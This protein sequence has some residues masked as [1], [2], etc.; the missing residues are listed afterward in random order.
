MGFL[1][2]LAAVVCV[3]VVAAVAIG[4]VAAVGSLFLDVAAVGL[5]VWGTYKL[6]SHVRERRALSGGKEPPRVEGRTHRVT[7]LDP[8]DASPPEPEVGTWEAWDVE[9]EPVRETKARETRARETETYGRRHESGRERG[10]TQAT[11][12]TRESQ[13]IPKTYVYLD[14]DGDTSAKDIERV[15]R[16]YR[17]VHV[18][19]SYADYVLDTLDA[20]EFRRRSLLPEIDAKFSQGT[21]SWE[22]FHVTACSALDAVLR[23]CALL[24]NRIQTFDVTEYGRYEQF[25]ADGAFSTNPNPGQATL[26]RWKLVCDTLKEMDELKDATEGLLHELGKLSAELSALDRSKNQENTKDIA[27]EVSRLV[28][29]TR[30]YR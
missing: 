14:V 3:I 24:G 15:M 5:L 2:L 12:T 6:I 22:R 7:V 21:I 18:V 26:G 29:E 4:L 13:S 10:R 11:G 25:M 28:D 16:G 20:L 17:S 19:G 23:N 1:L 9:P 30:Y 27:D 8:E